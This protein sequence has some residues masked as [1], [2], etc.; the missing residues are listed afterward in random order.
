MIHMPPSGRGPELPVSRHHAFGDHVKRSLVASIASVAL[1]L[2]LLAAAGPA[3][4]AVDSSVSESAAPVG[5]APAATPVPPDDGTP[6]DGE[7][8]VDPTF[9]TAPPSAAVLAAT[10]RPDPTLPP[11][12]VTAATATAGGAT[13][14]ALL[15]VLAA[16]STLILLATRTPHARRR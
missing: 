15:L 8:S 9:I 10:A 2:A 12:D 5:P 4:L 1:S 7:I 6:P 11:T 14:H 13:L 3:V 16:V